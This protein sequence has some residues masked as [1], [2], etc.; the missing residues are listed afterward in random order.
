M[1]RPC[2]SSPSE[3]P[4]SIA[5]ASP[6]GLNAEPA[7]RPVPGATFSHFFLASGRTH[8]RSGFARIARFS[9]AYGSFFGEANQS[10]PPTIA[11]T[12]PVVGFD[13]N[14][15]RVRIGCRRS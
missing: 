14:E 5:A 4:F 13:G 10:R 6:N 1:I 8:P 7:C 15:R 3:I 12:A 2:R 11:R 9:F